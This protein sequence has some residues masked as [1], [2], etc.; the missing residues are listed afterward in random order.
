MTKSKLPITLE[1]T[2]DLLGKKITIIITEDWLLEQPVDRESIHLSYLINSD[3]AH[4][5]IEDAIRMIIGLK[6]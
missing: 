2:P 3:E 6:L 1:S 5:L 4:G